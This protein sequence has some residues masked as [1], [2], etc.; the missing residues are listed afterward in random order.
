MRIWFRIV[1]RKPNHS[2][3]FDGDLECRIRLDNQETDIVF[4][5]SCADEGMREVMADLLNIKMRQAIAD[6][7]LVQGGFAPRVVQEDPRTEVEDDDQDSDEG[8]ETHREGG[9]S[10]WP[11][12]GGRPGARGGRFS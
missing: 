11:L 5:T 1:E 7:N 2:S 12:R 9:G 6:G 10:H 8:P 3:M 4:H